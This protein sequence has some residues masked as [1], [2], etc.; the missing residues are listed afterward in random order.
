MP[1]T[2]EI[3]AT[4]IVAAVVATSNDIILTRDGEI[5][6]THESDIMNQAAEQ[7]EQEMEEQV[8]GLYL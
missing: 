3:T 7:F 2:G 1:D 8:R 4:D 5:L 6:V